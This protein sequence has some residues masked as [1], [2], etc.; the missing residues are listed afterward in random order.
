[1]SPRAHAITVV[2]LTVLA[3]ACA[4][5]GD[6]GPAPTAPSPPSSSSTVPA[7]TTV[8]PAPGFLTAI[9]EAGYPRDLLQRGR[10]NVE[11]TNA[12]DVALRVTSRELLIDYFRSPGPEE[13]RSLIAAEQIEAALQTAL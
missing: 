1:M 4:A 7:S 2:A 6:A 12:G 13:R 5:D 9:T 10:V 3:G 8:A 11:T